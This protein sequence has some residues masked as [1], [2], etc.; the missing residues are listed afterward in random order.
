[1]SR[2]SLSKFCIV[3][4]Q[5][6]GSTWL[7]LLLGS[8]PEIK[9]FDEI[10][11]PDRPDRKWTKGL[12]PFYKF[13][14]SHSYKR[15]WLTLRYLDTLNTYSGDHK[16]IGFKLMYN[17][18]NKQPEILLKLLLDDFK[19]IHLVREN[20]LDIIQS[21]QQAFNR[22][23]PN[24]KNIIHT[25]K[26]VEI[27]PIYLPASSLLKR[28]YHLKNERIKYKIIL[29][30]L[31]NSVFRIT[32]KNLCHNTNTVLNSIA[33]FLNVK[34]SGIIYKS[35]RKKII[36]GK[37]SQMIS[38]YEEIQQLLKGTQFEKLLLDD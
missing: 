14:E 3:S 12:I 26:E 9:A 38:N 20:Y 1:M 16:V 30:I 31:P 32:Y 24:N 21:S 6:S 15:P 28:L 2:N 33:E 8:H 4:T 23:S 18:I 19:I 22:K 7:R 5:R 25:E 17:Q 37:K 35:D 36:T 11:L 34:S 29:N 27:L 13:K 10:F